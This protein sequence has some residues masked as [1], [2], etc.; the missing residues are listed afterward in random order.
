M[1]PNSELPR[2]AS[3]GLVTVAYLKAQI[4]DNNDHLGMFMPLV[5]DV[6]RNLPQNNVSTSD[7]QEGLFVRHG[8]VMPQPVLS[9]LLKRAVSAKW[10]RR[11]AGRY[12]K[13]P[14]ALPVSNDLET[15]KSMLKTAQA[16][17]GRALQSHASKRGLQIDSEFAAVDML[18]RFLEAEQVG[19]LLGDR[20]LTPDVIETDQRE[21]AI[22]AEFVQQTVRDDPSLLSILR[23]MIEGLVIYHAAFLPDLNTATQKFKNLRVVFDS[24]LVRQILGYEGPAM[25]ALMVETLAILKGVDVHCFVF[26]K[27]VEEIRGILKAYEYK[28]ATSSGRESMRPV[29]MARHFLTQKFSPSNV[30]EMSALLD[31]DITGAGFQIVRIPT[32]KK[33]HTLGELELIHRLASPGTSEDEI[34][35][36]VDHDV[37]CIAGVIQMREGVRSSRLEDTRAVFAVCSTL[38]IRNARLWWTED[39]HET[40]I[41]PVVHIRALAN[42]AWLKKPALK[43][44]FKVTELIALCSAAIRPSEELWTRFLK[45][46]EELKNSNRLSSDEITSILVSAMSDN[47]LRE[48][49]DSA[50]N[51]DDVDAVTLNE[52]VERVMNTYAS[53][54]ALEIQAVKSDYEEKIK[55]LSEMSQAQLGAISAE[56]QAKISALSTENQKKVDA[57]RRQQAFNEKRS[58]SL[59]R[60]AKLV[61][62]VF[63]NLVVLAGAWNIIR[64]HSVEKTWTGRVTLGTVCAFVFLELIGL[65]DHISEWLNQ[66]ES[67]ASN[68]ILSWLTPPDSE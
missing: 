56:N 47:L 50:D 37:D 68:K 16:R 46:L 13:I 11:E 45:Y 41:E 27:T 15:E 57:V 31:R 5:T 52:I 40:G 9:T 4:D 48:A 23:R 28:L 14:G 20:F 51:P 65:R 33:E 19:M 22:T 1:S 66:F 36:R 8:I 30:R 29:P 18:L 55:N 49:E 17:L 2:V 21:M 7:I 12:F 58:R 35:P 53:N 32:R 6:L 44:D 64:E 24:S 10:M 3:G 61:I 39:E 38:L 25:Q 59:A 63:T 34:E 62:Q 54:A 42:L 43:E 60:F 26:D 67:W